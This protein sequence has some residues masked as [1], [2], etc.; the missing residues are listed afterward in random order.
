MSFLKAMME[1]EPPEP[2]NPIGT[3]VIGNIEP[4]MHDTAKEQVR[5]A[6]KRAGFKTVDAGKSIAPQVFVDKAKESNADIIA[7]SVNTVPAKNNLAK[8]DEALKAAGLK[9]KIALIMG[10]AAVKKEDADA[11]GA[12]FGKNKEEGVEIAKKAMAA[13]KK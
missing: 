12:F 11:I 1:K 10:G 5:K 4:D 13:K 2:A 3:V 8:L 9:G 7:L 6:L